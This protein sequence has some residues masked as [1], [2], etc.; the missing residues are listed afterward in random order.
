[1]S[2]RVSLSIVKEHLGH[3]SAEITEKYY[4]HLDMNARKVSVKVLSN[5]GM[6]INTNSNIV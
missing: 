2:R 5:S 6:Q 4:G 3:S 1:M